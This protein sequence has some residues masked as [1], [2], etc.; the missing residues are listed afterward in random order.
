MLK[1]RVNLE[2]CSRLGIVRPISW[3][4]VITVC[5]ISRF[6]VITLEKKHFADCSFSFC[7]MYYVLVTKVLCLIMMQS[8]FDCL[9]C[10]PIA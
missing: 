4:K 7:S 9:L 8:V 1:M 2:T 5:P 3:F 6:K 10:K